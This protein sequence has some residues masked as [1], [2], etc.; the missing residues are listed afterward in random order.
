[1]VDPQRKESVRLHLDWTGKCKTCQFWNVPDGTA[2]VRGSSG[3]S[4]AIFECS[5]VRSAQNGRKMDSEGNC[6]QWDCFDVDTALEAM[7]VDPLPP[8]KSGE[9]DWYEHYLRCLQAAR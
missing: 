6:P 1:M 9:T 7:L 5:N 8:M 3:T 4:L 2:I